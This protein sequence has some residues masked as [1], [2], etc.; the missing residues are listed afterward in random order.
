M[1]IDY[2]KNEVHDNS[3]WFEIK[4]TINYIITNYHKF[5][6][7]ILAFFII[8]FVDYISNMNA[9]L[10]NGK[11]IPGLTSLKTPTPPLKLPKSNKKNRRK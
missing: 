9:F 1:D 8:Y 11:Y 6:L 10:Y 4:S 5:I 2:N 7:L 3:L